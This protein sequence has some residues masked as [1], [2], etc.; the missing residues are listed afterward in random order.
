[1]QP[2]LPTDPEQPQTLVRP[3]PP[4]HSIAQSVRALNV[5]LTQL[6]G[7]EAVEAMRAGDACSKVDV[8]L[9]G[10]AWEGARNFRDQFLL[11][12]ART[13][14]D[15]WRR[16]VSEIVEQQP[17]FNRPSMIAKA[18]DARLRITL[19]FAFQFLTP[20]HVCFL[21]DALMLAFEADIVPSEFARELATSASRSPKQTQAMLDALVLGASGMH[22][23]QPERV[24]ASTK[25]QGGYA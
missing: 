4:A 23:Y 12:L 1:V 14:R 25:T 2:N 13:T 8:G 16:D 11:S 10:P 9:W 6:S 5:I 22:R 21:A 19:D 3:I 15:E 18:L 17:E 20:R 24:M 7:K